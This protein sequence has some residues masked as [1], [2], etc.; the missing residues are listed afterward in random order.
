LVCRTLG[1]F[2]ERFVAANFIRIHRSEMIN[3]NFI[4]KYSRDGML[5]L[6]DGSRLIVSRRRKQEFFNAIAC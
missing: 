6:T 2:E 3:K 5:W 1:Y 4:A